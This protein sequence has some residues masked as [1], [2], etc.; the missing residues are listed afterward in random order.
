MRTIK[1]F[2]AF[3]L[4]AAIAT[5]AGWA[6]ADDISNNLDASVDAAAES[7][8]LL[9]PGP[10]A[11]TQLFVRTTSD[12]GKNGCNLT[13]STTLVVAVSSSSPAIATVSPSSVTFTAC[14]STPTLTVTPLR[15]GST[16]ISV[17]ETSN[18]TGGT[19]NLAPATF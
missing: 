12:D 14:G 5:P 10:P 18:N 11:T 16:T 17:A 19:F 7:M 6:R 13:G 4:L 3:I 9:F 2:I 15:A 8:A 1:T